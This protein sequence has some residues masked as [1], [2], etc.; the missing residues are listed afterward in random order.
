MTRPLDAE[1]IRQRIREGHSLTLDD[2]RELGWAF[3]TKPSASAF[4]ASRGAASVYGASEARCLQQIEAR[5]RR[6][7]SYKVRPAEPRLR[8][9]VTIY[10]A[11]LDSAA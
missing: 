2:A 7:L 5:E 1:A 9:L 8:P 10:G 6:M 4:K 11:D 3:N